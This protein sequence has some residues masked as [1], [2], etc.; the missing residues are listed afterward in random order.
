MIS[1]KYTNVLIHVLL[2]MFYTLIPLFY[3]LQR[4]AYDP[5]YTEKATYNNP[6]F[7]FF[8]SLSS[9]FLFYI[10]S[11]VLL[12]KFFKKKKALE[13]FTL[14]AVLI[15]SF[16]AIRIILRISITGK[17][18]ELTYYFYFNSLLPY[19]L[20]F[21]ISTSFRFFSD[22]VKEEKEK[23]ELENE[24]LKSELSFLRSQ[25][26]PHFMFNLMN[27]MV[28]LA[29]KKSDLLE[30]MLIKMSELLRYMLYE[31]DETKIALEKELA[32]L[33]NYI[34]L[35]ILRFGKKVEVNFSSN[36]TDERFKIEPML[37]IPFVENAFKHGTGLIEQPKIDIE[38]STTDSQI[39]F[40]VKNKFQ[41]DTQDSKD[42][43][44]GIG[45]ANVKRRLD[46]LYNNK[47]DLMI[48]NNECIFEINLKLTDL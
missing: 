33:K 22:Y 20:I 40:K 30:P 23:S 11:E 41:N 24:Q 48:K 34:D 8:V 21:A 5:S 39:D 19:L 25:I 4:L 14:L 7:W 47:Y 28:S 27:S 26:S 38:I 15:V 43:S 44:S 12:P 9:V 17:S 3:T 45:L 18:E 2:W 1:K 35:Q 6:I 13:Y 31:K 10:N 16:I 32:Y 46:L 42:P 36:V 37:L 29:R